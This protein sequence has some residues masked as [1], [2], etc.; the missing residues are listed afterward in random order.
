V[1]FRPGREAAIIHRLLARHEGNLPRRVLPRMWRELFAATTAMQGPYVIA[2]ADAPNTEGHQSLA[3]EHFGASTDF[4]I[5]SSPS[6]AMAD[7][8]SGAA[9]AAVLPM[10]GEDD[11][12]RHAWW[13]ALL[14]NDTP[15]I[16]IVARL[17]FWSP[18]ADGATPA[19]A[20]VVSTAAPDPSPHDHTL[21]GLEVPADMSRARISALFAE[22]GLPALGL[23]LRRAPQDVVAMV[24]ADVDGF[25]TEDDP[26]LASLA[27]PHKAVVL[28]AYA[29]P[30]G[31]E[32]A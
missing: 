4:R 9:I 27:S 28:G 19:R 29:K 11:E 22:A 20:L 8:S 14:Q 10:P 3:R 15:R 1:A 13:T 23:L 5:H 31:G 32:P 30:V 7:L 2:V 17:P 21:I 26:R 16:H 12:P 6:Q 24:L 18:R 25:V